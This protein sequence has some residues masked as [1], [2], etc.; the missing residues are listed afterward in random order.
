MNSVWGCLVPETKQDF[1][2]HRGMA[3]F[4]LFGVSLKAKYSKKFIMWNI[5]GTWSLLVELVQ[6]WF[7]LMV[8]TCLICVLR[9]ESVHMHRGREQPGNSQYPQYEE[10]SALLCCFF[11]AWGED[12]GPPHSC[13]CWFLSP[14]PCWLLQ[15][16]IIYLFANW[17]CKILY[18]VCY[19]LNTSATSNSPLSYCLWVQQWVSCS[20][21][22]FA[23]LTS[24][25][26]F[27]DVFALF[28]LSAAEKRKQ[29]GVCTQPLAHGSA[30]RRWPPREGRNYRELPD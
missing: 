26:W 14:H 6:A 22:S 21:R 3:K 27:V 24:K 5:M 15:C 11:S 28:L 1:L 17:T 18:L 7:C 29:G 12:G 10:Q 20:M 9:W 8:C 19:L 30:K 13:R 16:L 2:A 23:C 4:S 25:V